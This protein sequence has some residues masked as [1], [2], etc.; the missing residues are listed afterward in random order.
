M[1]SSNTPG[2]KAPDDGREDVGKK[3][4]VAKEAPMSKSIKREVCPSVFENFQR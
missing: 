2:L 1:G 3:L 4:K